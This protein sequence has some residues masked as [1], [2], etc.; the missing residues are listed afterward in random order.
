MQYWKINIV[1]IFC[2]LSRTNGSY[3]LNHTQCGGHKSLNTDWLGVQVKI[4]TDKAHEW[5]VRN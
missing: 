4:S 5:I 3:S 1:D 2:S